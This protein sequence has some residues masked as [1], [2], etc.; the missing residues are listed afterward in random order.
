[1]GKTNLHVLIM[2]GGKGERFWPQSREKTPKQFLS[3]KGKQSLIEETVDRLQGLVLP[4]QIWILTNEKHVALVQK[5]CPQLK[6]NQILGEPIGKDT[7]PC[8]AVAA[9]LIAKKDPQAVMVVLPA[10]HTISP[11]EK[12]HQIVKEAEEVASANKALITLGIPPKTPHTGYGY[13]QIEKPIPFS[14]KNRFFQVHAFK[15]KPDLKTAKKYLQKGNFYWNSGI[16]IWK[17]ETILQQIEKFLPNIYKHSQMIQ[18]AWGRANQQKVFRSAFNA[19]EKISIDYGV[20]EKADKVFMAKAPFEWDDLG[21]WI[22]L[23]HYLPQDKQGN[24][25]SG[26]VI[27]HHSK[28][29][30]LVSKSGL[31]ATLGVSDLI[32]VKTSDVTL[33]ASKDKEQEVK[34]LLSQI[35]EKKALSRYL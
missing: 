6:K 22:S 29:S 8:I 5:K 26:K 30:I 10:D 17:V 23:S 35:R 14:G 9:S 25:V 33:V 1:M 20:L 28:D 19:F 24:A 7:A 31:I 27:S 34:A 11:K 3:L 4:S 15:E 16:F 21:S 12:F 18:K 32:V 2:A 13:I